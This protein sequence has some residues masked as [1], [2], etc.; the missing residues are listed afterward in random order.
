[1]FPSKWRSIFKIYPTWLINEPSLDFNDH[2]SLDKLYVQPIASVSAIKKL[3]IFY[4][5]TFII[6]KH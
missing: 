5:P 3:P 6:F 2:F 1:M 4:H